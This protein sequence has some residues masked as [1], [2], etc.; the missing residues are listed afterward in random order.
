MT[1]LAE[2]FSNRYEIQ[3]GIARG[4]MAE[5]YL[6]RDQ[7]LD[8]PVAV[9]VLF[10]EYARDPS[11]V[12][13]FR[14]EAQ[15]AANLNHRNIVAIYDWGQE[16]GTYFIV[17]EYVRGR[18]LREIV[19]NNG[20]FS[21]RR[22]AEI[23]AEIAGALEF[24]HR[25]G[26]VHRDVKPGNV[27][28]TA[29]DDVKVTDFGIARADAGEALTQTGAV[30]GTAT[31]FSPEQAQGL[32]VDGRSDVY[33]LGVVLYEMATGVPP[34]TGES[35]VAVAYKHVRENPD[36]PRAHAPDLPPDLEQIILTA[37]SKDVDSRY[38]TADELRNDLLRFLRGQPPLG[39]PEPAVIA[40]P[41]AAADQTA[42]V[43]ATPT[44][45]APAAVP[46]SLED[47]AD[48]KRRRRRG[49]I[50]AGVL[51]AILIAAVVIGLVAFGGGG[52]GGGGPT[53]EVP[54]LINKSF[55]DA[56]RILKLI[57][58]KVERKDVEGK[59]PPDLVLSQNPGAGEKLKKNDAV[60]LRVAKATFTMP[61]LNGAQ[62]TD[63]VNTLIGKGLQDPNNSVVV[64][65][66]DSDQASPGTV[67][68][69]DPAAGTPWPKAGQKVTLIV[70]K[71]PNIVVP[72][73]A[74]QEAQTAQQLLQGQGFQ[75]S[76]QSEPSD[77]VPVGRVTRSDPGAGTSVKKGSAVKLFVSAG[78][79]NV[80]VPNVVGQ[81]VGQAT[82]TLQA[83]GFQVFASEQATNNPS[84]NGRV[85]AQNPAAGQQV[86]KGSGVTLTVGRFP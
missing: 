33:S 1:Q 45:V 58:F 34:F 9:K 25:N 24:A 79:E 82:Q 77:S 59:D 56:E 16:R 50:V 20:A 28:L 8:R 84:E 62:R 61:D 42:A 54:N 31:Y 22:A 39:G 30:M 74:G 19:H 70:A 27:L 15:S 17:M 85:L 29:D 12:E 3:R 51:G 53:A 21:P 2:V 38:Q 78:P 83:A 71:E 14:R 68:R 81:Q 80:Q 72:N 47:D 23:G 64:T 49:A 7:L 52:G 60:V 35:P 5:V 86:P 10:P 75:V 6:A 55:P 4:G 43:A 57:G 36:P 44:Q 63:A 40:A 48:E 76:L 41:I 65:E 11:F 46:T 32:P 26:V 18:S 37:M 73:L 13:R 69:S 67:L 66:E